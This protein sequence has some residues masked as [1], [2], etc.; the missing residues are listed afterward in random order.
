MLAPLRPYQREVVRAVLRSVREGDGESFSVEIA[1]QGG[2]NE[3]SA[4]IE[5][6]LLASNADRDCTLVKAAPTLRPQARISFDRLWTRIEDAGFGRWAK[7]SGADR[8]TFG[9][10]IQ[11][12]LS[13]EPQSN[14]VGHTA[15][16]LLEVDEAQDVDVEKFDRELR[17]MAASTGATTVFYGTA[18]DNAN[19]LERVKQSHLEAERRDGRRR[20]FEYDWEMVGRATPVYARFARQERDRLGAE[21]PVFLSQYCLRVLAG[22]GRLLSP[23]ALSLL[24]GSHA[25]LEGPIAGEAYVA[26]LDVA[27]EGEGAHDA[28]VLTIARVFGGDSRSGSAV[29]TAREDDPAKGRVPLTLTLSPG[30]GD[31]CNASRGDKL[32]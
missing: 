6:A 23:T 5:L 25:R 22:A 29:R 21:H 2:K 8:I 4:R 26:G 9:R 24:L 31:K 14:I 17:P 28:T 27:G 1:R 30:R 3:L 10:A 11:V 12:F 7:R 16:L 20:H 18:W 19:L 15:S 13:A 32:G